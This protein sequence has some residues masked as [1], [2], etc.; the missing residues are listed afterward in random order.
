[1]KGSVRF[2]VWVEDNPID[3]PGIV[4]IGY[5]AESGQGKMLLCEE[6]GP[7]DTTME[8]AVK[9]AAILRKAGIVLA[10]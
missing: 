8:L 3:G 7:F 1:M 6:I 4:V 9:L 10:T 2:E 5:D